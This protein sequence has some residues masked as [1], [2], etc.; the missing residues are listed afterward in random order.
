MIILDSDSDRYWWKKV[1]VEEIENHTIMQGE[2]LSDC[3]IPIIPPDFDSR[4]DN[5][6]NIP[7]VDFDIDILDL[8]VVTQS[9][10]L[11]NGKVEFVL[12]C[13]IYLISEYKKECSDFF[14]CQDLK[15]DLENAKTDEHVEKIKKA[16]ENKE[17]KK[18]EEIRKGKYGNLF[19]LGSTETPE[20]KETCLVVDFSQVHTL[21]IGY[22]M[23]HAKALD[24]RWRLKSPHLEYFSHGFGNRFTRVALPTASILP[25]FTDK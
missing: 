1:N 23:R 5:S 10:D 11:E 25:K 2:Y 8:I 17:N 9:C 4:C 20:N 13:P 16:I 21:P 18:M 6:G 19:L 15:K 12:L 24:L 7:K 14:G 22:L 3:M